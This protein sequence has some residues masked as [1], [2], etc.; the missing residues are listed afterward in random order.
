MAH[1]GLL[2]RATALLFIRS[3]VLPHDYLLTASD[4]KLRVG[5]VLRAAWEYLHRTRASID[6]WILFVAVVGYIL[7]AWAFIITAGLLMVASIAHAQTAGSTSTSY[8]Q[9]PNPQQD[10]AQNW[11]NYLFFAQDVSGY[12]SQSGQVIPQAV[13]IQKALQTALAFYSDAILIVAGVLLFYH[14]VAM[15]VETAHH[16]VPMGKRANQIWA[17]IRLV[18]AIGL[19]VPVS[20]GLNCGQYIVVQIAEWGSGLAS[21]TWQVFLTALAAQGPTYHQPQT[22]YVRKVVED[23]IAINACQL[24]FNYQVASSLGRFGTDLTNYLIQPV[25]EPPV[26]DPETGV[27]VAPGGSKIEYTSRVQGEKNMCGSYDMGGTSTP[28]GSG[29][30]N[31]TADFQAQIKQQIAQAHLQT[32]Q[33]LL[34]ANGPLVAAAKNVK[35]Y[36]GGFPHASDSPQPAPTPGFTAGDFLASDNLP[37]NA[38][39]DQLVTQYQATLKGA[40]SGAMG[41]LQD[42]SLKNIATTWSGQG[43][44]TAGAWFNT[45]ARTQGAILDATQDGLPVTVPPKVGQVA[46]KTN[47]LTR[48]AQWLS[49]ERG[50]A[51]NSTDVYNLVMTQLVG[52]DSWLRSGPVS[53]ST[54]SMQDPQKAA[55][56]RL[57]DAMDGTDDHTG[58][59]IINALLW[60]VDQAA[61]AAGAWSDGDLMYQ[62]AGSANP[63]AEIAYLGHSNLSLGLN[64]LGGAGVGQLAGGAISFLGPVGAAF[65]K[66]LGILTAIMAF[67]GLVFIAGGFTL[68]FLVPLMPYI[69]FF[70][71]V[72]TWML[73]VVEA[74]VIVPVIALAHLNPEGDGLPGASAKQA[75]FLLFNILLRPVLM[76]FGLIFGLLLFFVGISF[77]NMTFQLAAEGTGGY[78]GMHTIAKIAFSVIYVGLVYICASHCFRAIGYFPEH[79]LRWIGSS[80]H[81]EN[82][83]TPE[84]MGAVMTGVSAYAGKELGSAV[85]KPGQAL[86][87]AAQRANAEKASAIASQARHVQQLAHRAGQDVA[88]FKSDPNNKQYFE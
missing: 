55:Q 47:F 84:H 30:S 28:Q 21:Q 26:V 8:F 58:F 5:P 3:G 32:I 61:V 17:P 34:A 15:V 78:G 7:T 70:F 38:V 79:A 49:G 54:T 80:G 82:M 27:I 66:G 46:E 60:A 45:I 50:A 37:T 75:Y 48:S 57:K 52:F 22:P 73:A 12:L 63:L 25:G 76:V 53:G 13:T 83:G 77:L 51:R 4:D 69:W 56:D 68:A 67:I 18:V 33:T 59:N 72:L 43:W 71:N 62:F 31:P 64:L 88:T 1:K 19:L 6:K 81:H 20:G 65:G 74:V 23:L 2:A 42:S 36:I 29:V 10:M 85:Q 35:F 14:L 40:L 16:G 86:G 39:V 87:A 44:V 24:D 41:S 9:P 11:L